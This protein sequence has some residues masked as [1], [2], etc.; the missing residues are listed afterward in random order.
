MPMLN[1]GIASGHIV[2][3]TNFSDLL[4]AVHS[5]LKKETSLSDVFLNQ[6]EKLFYKFDGKSGQRVSQL[7]LDCIKNYPNKQ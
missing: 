7:L 2:K 4:P 1:E 5:L 6:R 3:C